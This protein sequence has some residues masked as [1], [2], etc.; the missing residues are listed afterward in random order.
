MIDPLLIVRKSK[1]IAEDLR[2]LEPIA[3]MT[4]EEYLNHHT[5]QVLSER[6]LERLIGRMIDINYHLLTETGNPPPSDY[7]HSFTELSKMGVL[8]PDFARD[9]ARSAGLRNRLV[10]EY[11]EIEPEKVYEGIKAAVSAVPK[12]LSLVKNYAESTID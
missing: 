1:L 3:E 10:H 12:Y 11:D 2:E 6:Y 7:F 5:K 9:I 4:L 8:P